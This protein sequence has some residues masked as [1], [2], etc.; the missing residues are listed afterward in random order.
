MTATILATGDLVLDESG[1]EAYFAPTASTLRSGDIVIGHIETPYQF[2]APADA[3]KSGGGAPPDDPFKLAVLPQVG[4]NVATTSGNHVYDLGDVGVRDTLRALH[5]Y[6]IVTT[7]SGMDLAEARQ[8]AIIEKQGV[9]VGVLG[10][11]AVGP[12]TGFAGTGKAGAAHVRIPGM[13]RRG[14]DGGP[15]REAAEADAASLAEMVRDVKALRGG[16]DVVVVSFHKGIVHT[17]VTV[18]P[19][20][21]VIAHAAIDAGADVVISHHAH[22]CRGIEIYKGKPI[23][24]GLGNF[25]TVTNVLS[26]NPALNPSPERLEYARRRKAVFNFEPDAEMPSYYAFH[27]ESRSTLIAKLIVDKTGVR[28]TRFIPVWIDAKAYPNV[29]T[30]DG[31]GQKVVDYLAKITREAGLNATFRWSEKGDEVIVS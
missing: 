30:R 23:F 17:P 15:S 7:G 19:Y 1:I 28:E 24:H 18:L 12:E 21:K 8:P 31:G 16:V 27:P 5:S 29:V 20:E 6:G 22:I 26:D 4:F 10:Y 14:V 25:V 9:K 11:L 13:L 3:R 2:D